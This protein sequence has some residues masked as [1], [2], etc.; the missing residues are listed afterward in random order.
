[1]IRGLVFDIDDTLYLERDYVRSGFRAVARAATS[2][3]PEA[4]A[5]SAWLWA[6]FESGIRDDTFDRM[7]AAFPEVRARLTVHEMVQVY[8]A[9]EPAIALADGF[10]PTLDQLAVRG[11]RLGVLSDGPAVSQAAKAAALGLHRWFDPIVL[12]GALGSGYAKPST[13]GFA[14]IADGWALEPGE[15]GYI[16]DNPAKDFAGPR[17]LGWLTVRFRAPGQLRQALEATDDS[18]R[19]DVEVRTPAELLDLRPAPV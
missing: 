19:P 17:R 16:G 5:V 10:A 8:R 7:L 18:F 13:A 12:T 3:E 1:M 9:H 6:A 4:T 14:S 11:L 15:L 2:S